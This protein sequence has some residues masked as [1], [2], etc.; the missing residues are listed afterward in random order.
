MKTSVQLHQFTQA[1]QT[2][3]PFIMFIIS[4]VPFI[5]SLFFGGQRVQIET[6]L[7]QGGS[8][9]IRLAGPRLIEER[10]SFVFVKIRA[11]GHLFR[12]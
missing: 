6:Y 9:R 2:D 4:V 11:N 5:K 1:K 8:E 7:Q 3:E 10:C 12:R